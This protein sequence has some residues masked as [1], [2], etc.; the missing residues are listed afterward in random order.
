MTLHPRVVVAAASMIEAAEAA[1]A[2]AHE[3]CFISNSVKFPVRHDA[4]VTA[5]GD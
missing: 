1:H 3:W 4:V 2:Q 5:L